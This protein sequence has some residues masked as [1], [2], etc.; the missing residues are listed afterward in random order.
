MRTFERYSY[1]STDTPL[2]EWRSNRCSESLRA[3]PWFAL[4]RRSGYCLCS[5]LMRDLPLILSSDFVFRDLPSAP[6][7]IV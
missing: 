2:G 1:K 5:T 6:T 7:E 3:S 4:Q